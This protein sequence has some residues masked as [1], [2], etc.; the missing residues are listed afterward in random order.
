MLIREKLPQG[1]IYPQ[2]TQIPEN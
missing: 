1:Y 2:I